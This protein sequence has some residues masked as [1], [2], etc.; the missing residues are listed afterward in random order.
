MLQVLTVGLPLT[1]SAIGERSNALTQDTDCA[2][3]AKMLFATVSALD[4]WS[5]ACKILGPI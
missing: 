4:A 1:T 5:H 2:Q 3:P